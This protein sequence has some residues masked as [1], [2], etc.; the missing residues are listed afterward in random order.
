MRTSADNMK[1]FKNYLNNKERVRWLHLRH[2][3]TYTSKD[4]DNA[5]L[6]VNVL[7]ASYWPM[8]AQ[9]NTCT[10]PAVMMRLQQQYERFYLQRHSGRRMLWQVTQGT[11]DLKVQFKERKYEVNVSTLGAIILLLFD[12]V[13]DEEWVSYSD[14]LST[15]NIPENELKRNLQTLACGKYKLLEKD[16]KSKDVRTTDK[17]RVNANFSSPLAKIKIATIANRVET[18]EERKETD[19]K[20]EEERKHQT[21]V[22]GIG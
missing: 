10:L 22:S 1:A 21:D 2:H 13:E 12:D 19:E 8:S 14:I 7:T 5:D 3:T 17:F 20:V 16:P 4:S 6:N 18:T 9:V 11:V 15:T